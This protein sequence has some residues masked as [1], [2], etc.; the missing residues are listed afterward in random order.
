MLETPKLFGHLELKPYLSLSRGNKRLLTLELM[1]TNQKVIELLPVFFE[2]GK[3]GTF[4]RYFLP[5][6]KF[7]GQHDGFHYP[8]NTLAKSCSAKAGGELLLFW[9]HNDQFLNSKN[10]NLKAYKLGIKPKSQK[11]RHEVKTLKF[12]C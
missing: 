3:E 10:L 6:S 4:L 12:H 2:G 11:V 8:G 9:T 7:D 5:P 1:S